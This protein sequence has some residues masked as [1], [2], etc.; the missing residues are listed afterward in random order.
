MLPFHTLRRELWVPHPQAAVF[1]FF[2]RA[3]NLEQLTPPWMHFRILTA[4]PIEMKQGVN[5]R[6]ALR[7]R[8]FPLRWLTNIERWEPPY[9]FVDVQLKG[10]Y[11]MWRHTHRFSSLR[12]GTTMVDVVQY[13]LPFGPLGQL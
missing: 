7:V 6:Y 3:E 12:G 9:E 13:R 4:Q 8:G 5:I 2:S 10:P 11:T 1:D